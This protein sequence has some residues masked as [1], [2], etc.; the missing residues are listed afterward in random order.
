MLVGD[1]VSLATTS[2]RGQAAPVGTSSL[3]K[4]LTEKLALGI[5]SQAEYDHIIGVCVAATDGT[6]GDVSAA[7]RSSG[8]GGGAGSGNSDGAKTNGGDGPSST[9]QRLQH[10]RAS[11]EGG[12]DTGSNRPFS[13]GGS[14]IKETDID[15][16]LTR[17]DTI[18]VQAAVKGMVKVDDCCC[19]CHCHCYCHSD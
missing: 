10:G 1:R 3:S 4:T 17:S 15:Q 9:L 14:T 19:H 18:A 16:H 6:D 8:S 7:S 12:G 5:I 2:W 11:A 13:F